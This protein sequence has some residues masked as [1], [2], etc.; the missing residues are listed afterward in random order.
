MI[1]EIAEA[2]PLSTN[3][4]EPGLPSARP[5]AQKAPSG[6]RAANSPRRWCSGAGVAQAAGVA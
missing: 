5:C 3:R 2:L 4:S 6:A 1:Y